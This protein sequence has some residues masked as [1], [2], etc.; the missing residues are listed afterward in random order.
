[1]NGKNTSN[2]KKHGVSFEEAQTAFHDANAGYIWT[3]T[4]L[5]TRTDSS[6]SASVSSFGYWSCA[7]AIGR[8]M[9]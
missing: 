7:I 2:R 5:T 9:T 1:M 3:R 8:T 4:T 6:C